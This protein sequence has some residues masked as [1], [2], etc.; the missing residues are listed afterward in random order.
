MKIVCY[1]DSNTYGHD[2]RNYFGGRYG[3]DSRWVE[4]LAKKTGWEIINEGMNGREIP[5]KPIP[6]PTDVDMVFVM[7]GTNDLLQGVSSN[8]A[9][10]KMEQWILSLGEGKEKLL[11]IAPPSMQFGEWVRERKLIE[12][13]VRLSKSY[14]A[15]ARRIGVRFVDAEKWNILMAFDGVHFTGEEHKAFAEKLWKELNR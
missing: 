13:S 8:S 1:G 5:G 11:L 12:D 3:A 10:E 7:L 15:L 2:P 4:I 14:A 9:A 6:V